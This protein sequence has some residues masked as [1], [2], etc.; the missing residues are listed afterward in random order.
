[1]GRGGGGVDPSWHRS[2]RGL[3]KSNSIFDF[4]SCGEYLI[5]EGY[6]HKCRL[7]AVGCSAGCLLAGAASNMYPELF[8]AI[9]LKVSTPIE[10]QLSHILLPDGYRTPM[11]YIQKY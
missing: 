6:V 9:I 1:M 10:L 5:N 7:G 2:G 11:S 4:V 3:Y 8:R